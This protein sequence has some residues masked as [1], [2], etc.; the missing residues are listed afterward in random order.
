M[1]LAAGLQMWR[2]CE[3]CCGFARGIIRING[4]ERQK[5]WRKWKTIVRVEEEFRLSWYGQSWKGVKEMSSETPEGGC[6]EG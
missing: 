6:Q 3:E 5:Q 2:C 1:W 4:V